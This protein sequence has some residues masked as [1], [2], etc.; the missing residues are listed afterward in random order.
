MNASTGIDKMGHITG[1]LRLQAYSKQNEL[2]WETSSH[3]LIV[4]SGYWSVAK[5]LA[6]VPNMSIAKIAIGTN[7]NP[8]QESDS[9][10]TNAVLIDIQGIE[11]PKKVTVRFHFEIGYS[12]ATGMNIREFG[13]LTQDGNLFSRKVREVIEKTQNFRIIGIWDVNI[14]DGD[15]F[16]DYNNDYNDDYLSDDYSAGAYLHVNPDNIEVPGDI[17]IL[18]NKDWNIN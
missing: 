8:A 12:D 18:T 11:Y 6:G 7:G 16:Y 2:L 9:Q 10:I 1:I 3:N 13:L 14:C 5:A 4:A 15:Y 17:D